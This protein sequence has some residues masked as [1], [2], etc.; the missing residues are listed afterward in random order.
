MC[1]VA[2]F[3]YKSRHNGPPRPKNRISKWL[4]YIL[5]ADPPGYEAI[6]HIPGTDST[7]T[8]EG[9]ISH[10]NKHKASVEADNTQS[11]SY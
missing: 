2:F 9:E 5:K 1:L 10:R 4:H 6:T 11:I 7:E 8:L 3:K